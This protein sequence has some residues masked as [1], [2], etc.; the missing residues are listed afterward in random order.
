MQDPDA[1]K[2][3]TLGFDASGATATK[4]ICVGDT[5]DVTMRLSNNAK[6]QTLGSARVIFPSFVTVQ[7]VTANTCLAARTQPCGEGWLQGVHRQAQGRRG[8]LLQF[9]DGSTGLPGTV[10]VKQANQFNDSTGDANLF[11]V[12]PETSLPTLTA[13]LC[14]GTISGRI[15]QDTDENGQPGPNENPQAFNVY[16][17][18]K[19]TAG[20]GT[21][22]TTTA[23]QTGVYTFS[24]VPL[25]KTYLVCESDP[26]AGV[27]AQSTP[28][29]TPPPPPK[30]ATDG[31]ESNGW[32]FLFGQSVN[33]KHFGNVPAVNAQCNEAFQGG[34]EGNFQ[35]QA[36]LHAVNGDCKTGELVMLTYT[37]QQNG[38]V[39]TLHPT[40]TTAGTKFPVIEWIKWTGLTGTAQN[41]VTLRYDDIAPYGDATRE[42]PMCKFD[43][44]PDGDS[45]GLNDATD[46][47][48]EAT[49]VHTSC[50][51]VS[52]DS[53]GG[54]YEAYV[55]S[56]VDGYRSTG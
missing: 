35:Y 17:Y 21:P 6:S 34:V 40:N 30:C 18:E 25:N 55:Y 5:V 38:L 39:A 11:E 24:N 28:P 13:A 42:M 43:P 14:I 49:P 2:Y 41:P 1:Q 47:F 46:I 10:T 33:D 3:Y 26:L 44:R 19:T 22:R 51:I 32:E 36:K 48:P 27:W 50:M 12:D 20:Y 9:T 15:W 4:S 45:F 7:G 52:T 56:E 54:T 23:S 29:A 16:L 8:R 31:R 53:A 37:S